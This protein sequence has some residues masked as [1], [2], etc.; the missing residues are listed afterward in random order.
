M[1]TIT[2]AGTKGYNNVGLQSKIQIETSRL[3]V[4]SSYQNTGFH[5]SSHMSYFH[6]TVGMQHSTVHLASCPPSIPTPKPSLALSLSL[7][8]FFSYHLTDDSFLSLHTAGCSLGHLKAMSLYCTKIITF[9][10]RT[11]HYIFSHCWLQITTN[12]KTYSKKK[13]IIRIRCGTFYVMNVTKICNHVT[14]HD[15][16]S[17]GFSGALHPNEND[18]RLPG[19]HL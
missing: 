12:D 7:S 1:T 18:L 11:R 2:R 16:S 4:H 9:I 17:Y 8:L 15:I 14:Y 5:T 3:W 10:F 6:P 13:L 19:S